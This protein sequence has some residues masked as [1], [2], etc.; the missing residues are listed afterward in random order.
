MLFGQEGHRYW[1]SNNRTMF[2]KQATYNTTQPLPHGVCHPG[3]PTRQRL[4][5]RGLSSRCNHML[6]HF[7]RDTRA[8][9]CVHSDAPPSY[10]SRPTHNDDLVMHHMLQA[11]HFAAQRVNARHGRTA[12][13]DMQDQ[14]LGTQG[15][16]S[17]HSSVLSRRALKTVHVSF[18]AV[19]H[20]AS[21]L[22]IA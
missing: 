22:E 19:Q 12:S 16:Y 18:E 21:A 6:A 15:P 20:L 10:Y 7:S 1:L 3:A 17:A 8:V 13:A 14:T 4:P 5:Q 9:V 2:N 11:S